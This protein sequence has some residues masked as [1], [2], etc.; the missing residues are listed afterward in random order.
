MVNE[1]KERVKQILLVLQG[2][3]R[4][5][6]RGKKHKLEGLENE[7]SVYRVAYLEAKIQI[8]KSI[9]ELGNADREMLIDTYKDDFA[10]CRVETE[11]RVAA[12][13]RVDVTNMVSTSDH[14]YPSLINTMNLDPGQEIGRCN[15]DDKGD[16]PKGRRNQ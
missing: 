7:L 12:G 8:E 6:A 11:S 4:N 14:F 5:A 9:L 10:Y 1:L 16:C 2:I 15:F 13:V 3:E